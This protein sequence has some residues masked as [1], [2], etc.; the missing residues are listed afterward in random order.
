MSSLRRNIIRPLLHEFQTSQSGGVISWIGSEM[1]QEYSKLCD[2]F[3][4]LTVATTQ[5]SIGLN[6]W[7][8]KEPITVLLFSKQTDAYLARFESY[9]E[10]LSLCICGGLF[11]SLSDDMVERIKRKKSSYL[12]LLDHNASQTSSPGKDAA[13][14][15]KTEREET[16][17][18]II[19]AF[20]LPHRNELEAFQKNNSN[21]ISNYQQIINHKLWSILLHSP[22]QTAFLSD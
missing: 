9:F 20:S 14:D 11:D 2:Q 17:E 18:S 5:N 7:I 6:H 8:R 15:E 10:K 22:P 1:N 3:N 12:P 19:N 4:Q 16:I 21:D 13:G